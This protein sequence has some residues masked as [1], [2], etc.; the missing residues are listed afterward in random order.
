LCER[1]RGA[2]AT[3]EVLG[4]GPFSHRAR[5]CHRGR[6][7]LVGDAAGCLDP[8]TGEGI[9]VGLLS[10]QSLVD[11]IARGAPLSRYAR[12]RQRILLV[13]RVL[14]QLLLVAAHRPAVRH[15]FARAMSRYPAIFD[16]LVALD[17]GE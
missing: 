12:Q 6:V 9:N 16:R 3:S 4:A 8:L 1:V 2:E 13:P 5:R 17:A 7:A 10:A 15:G 14:T 11:T